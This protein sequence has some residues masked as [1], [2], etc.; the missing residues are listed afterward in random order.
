MIDFIFYGIGLFALVWLVMLHVAV[1]T[2]K[3]E[4]VDQSLRLR[5]LQDHV[6]RIQREVRGK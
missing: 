5:A 3:G 2:H 6:N 1:T 4:L